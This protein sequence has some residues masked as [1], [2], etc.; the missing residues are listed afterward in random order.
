LRLVDFSL[1]RLGLEPRDLDGIVVA[2]GPGSFTGLR[3][4]WATAKGLAQEAGLEVRAI[5]ALMAAAAGAAQGR[6][7]APIA[8]WFDALR[9]DVYAAIYRFG[10]AAVE[11]LLPPTVIAPEACI[12]DSVVRPVLVVGDG[13]ARYADQARG[14]TGAEPRPRG[15]APG[16]AMLLAL[17]TLQGAGRVLE[18]PEDAEPVYGRLAEA[19]AR[20]EARHGRL[21]DPQRPAP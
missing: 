21:L 3:I 13:A 8:A 9:G 1:G 5:P 11:T 17:L 12:R 2:D 6:E 14:W 18:S 20:W 4:G 19:Q 16:A 15:L 10:P 7:P